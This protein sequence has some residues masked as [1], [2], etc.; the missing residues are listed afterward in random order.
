LAVKASSGSRWLVGSAGRVSP[1]AAS[2]D[3]TTMRL[4]D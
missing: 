4:S 2:T 3:M 1:W